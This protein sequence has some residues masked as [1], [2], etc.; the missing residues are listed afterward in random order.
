[1][2]TKKFIQE[3]LNEEFNP[4]KRMAMVKAIM[5]KCANHLF[6]AYRELDTAIQYCDDPVVRERLESIRRLLGNDKELSWF[7]THETPSVIT[8]LQDLSS[9]VDPTLY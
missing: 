4:H 7:S 6:D 3:K 8:D 9:R 1:M 2:E 5:N